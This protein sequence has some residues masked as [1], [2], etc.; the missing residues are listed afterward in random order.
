V[1]AA[2]GDAEELRDA[3]RRLAPAAVVTDIRMPPRHHMEGI[4]AGHAFRADHPGAGGAGVAQ[5]IA[6][7][8]VRVE[9]V[10]DVD[11]VLQ[12]AKRHVAECRLKGA[13]DVADRSGRRA[14]LV[15]DDLR[16]PVEQHP[17]RRML[18][19]VLVRLDLREESVSIGFG[20]TAI[21]A[22][23]AAEVL[24]A[25][26]DRISSSEHTGSEP[27]PQRLDRSL[28]HILTVNLHT[29][30]MPESMPVGY[31]SSVPTIT[32]HGSDLA[33]CRSRLWESNPRPTHYEPVPLRS[34]T[35]PNP[36]L[37]RSDDLGRRRPSWLFLVGHRWSGARRGH[38]LPA[39][40][41]TAHESPVVSRR[42][43]VGAP[44]HVPRKPGYQS[45]SGAPLINELLVPNK[46]LLPFWPATQSLLPG[47]SVGLRWAR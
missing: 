12:L 38:R 31:R 10:E 41:P 15:V 25:A 17:D 45:G 2:V 6:A 34:F 3:V 44:R 7:A 23:L 14:Q 22:G 28:C 42:T 19:G 8:Q 37:R 26:G 35:C 43:Q 4:V 39:E 27:G 1:V 5:P 30:G 29:D 9:P 13:P 18:V 16:P 40:R 36:L 20:V 11:P 32:D 24:L 46:V 33:F 47:H 21:S